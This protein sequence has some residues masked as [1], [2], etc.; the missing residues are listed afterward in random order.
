[1]TENL[2]EIPQNLRDVSEQNLKRAHAAYEQLMDFVTKAVG[3][4]MGAMPA[5]PMVAGFKEVQNR[6]AEIAK[7]NADSAF[8]LVEKIAKAR[9]SQTQ[10]AQDQMK[11]F[12]TQT[13]QLFSVMPRSYSE[14]RTRAMDAAM[15]AMP[16]NPM[17]A[18][19]KDV[20]D[21]AVH[22]AMENAES[23]FA[24]ADKICDALAFED[25][26]TLQTQ[27]AQE[28]MQALV[29]QTQQLYSV[30]EGAIQKSERGATGAPMGARPSNLMAAGF[31]DVQDRAV[32]MAKKNADS[33][34]ALVEKIAK[35]QNFQEIVTLQTRFAQQQ[36]QEL[37]RLMEKTLQK[38]QRGRSIH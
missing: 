38:L 28:R 25:I 37:Q 2:F 33:A 9:F 14:V 13:Q 23:A 11:A 12:T 22:I 20:Q 1:M 35:A 7:K 5:S 3:A 32:A 31:K 18:G 16:A 8:A 30:I 10:F 6:A 19:F 36:M 4:W 15:D 17:T 27:F 24:F 34:F 26:V 21:R 29:T